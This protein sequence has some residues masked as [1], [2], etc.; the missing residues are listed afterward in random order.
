MGRS[1]VLR[2][3]SRKTKEL[4]TSESTQVLSNIRATRRQSWVSKPAGKKYGETGQTM[5]S[6][7]GMATDP[8]FHVLKDNVFKWRTGRPSD[9][10]EMFFGVDS[11][12]QEPWKRR[13][14]ACFS[15]GATCSTSEEQEKA[16]HPDILGGFY[17]PSRAHP[18]TRQKRQRPLANSKIPLK[19]VQVRSN[20]YTMDSD[21]ARNLHM[22]P[23]TIPYIQQSANTRLPTMPA[24]PARLVATKSSS[25]DTNANSGGTGLDQVYSGCS[26]TTNIDSRSRSR[27]STYA[28]SDLS[29]VENAS[30]GSSLRGQW[31]S[32]SMRSQSQQ[33]QQYAKPP[34]YVCNAYTII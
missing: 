28:V 19:S 14:P 21:Y 16:A 10:H 27:P 33:K 9:F 20:I 24:W 34:R 12:T 5:R 26:K 18:P 29:C 30:M 3:L 7:R 15:D 11:S 32:P 8:Q 6:M 23:F 17:V 25:A 1:E 22:G 31:L 4:E 13:N 2:D